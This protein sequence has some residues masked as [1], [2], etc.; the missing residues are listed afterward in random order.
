MFI[1]FTA[2]LVESELM[3]PSAD[4]VLQ[5]EFRRGLS[6]VAGHRIL[7]VADAPGSL[8]LVI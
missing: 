4:F 3:V 5:T 6:S 7:W 2:E 1:V 8:L